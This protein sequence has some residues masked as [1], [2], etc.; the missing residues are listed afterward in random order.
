VV[1]FTPMKHRLLSET[2]ANKRH[3]WLRMTELP[4]SRVYAYKLI[5]SGILNSVLLNNPGSKKGIRLVDGDSLDSYLMGLG[6][7]QAGKR[8]GEVLKSEAA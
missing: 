8:Q 6:K 2:T 3:R 5:D 4:F 7:E 1:S